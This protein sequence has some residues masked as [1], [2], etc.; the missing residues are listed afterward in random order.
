MKIIRKCYHY[1]SN[2]FFMASRNL[3]RSVRNST[4]FMFAILIPT[5]IMG[6]FVFVFGTAIKT[7]DVDYINYSLPAIWIVAIGF[8]GMGIAMSVYMDFSSGIIDR[9]RSMPISRSSI[10]HGY[11]LAVLLRSTISCSYLLGLAVLM[12]FNTSAGLAEFAVIYLLLLL[13]SMAISWVAVFF[14]LIAKSAEHADS[15]GMILWMLPYISSAFV[16]T[17]YMPKVIKIIAE[18]QP[19][20]PIIKTLRSFILT[21]KAGSNLTAAMVWCAALFFLFYLLSIRLFNKKTV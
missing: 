16:P 21:G 5:I 19:V 20:D 15:L 13:Y 3:L 8:S 18:N 2:L 1:Q 4:F 11:V 7:G 12:G 9:F 10:L 14:G 6:L 17:E